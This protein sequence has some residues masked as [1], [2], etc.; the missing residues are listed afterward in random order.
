LVGRESA[1][2][3]SKEAIAGEEQARKDPKVHLVE[4]HNAYDPDATEGREIRFGL[5]ALT[6]VF[7]STIEQEDYR[8][9]ETTQRSA[10]DG[11]LDHLIFGRNE[12]ALHHYHR[13][14]REALGMPPLEEFTG[15]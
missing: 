7:D 15:R 4:A 3:F 13:S 14:Y 12:P 1:H 9:G 10:E 8:V 2:Y 11:Q 6:E 5:S